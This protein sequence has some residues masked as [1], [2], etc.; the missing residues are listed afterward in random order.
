MSGYRFLMGSLTGRSESPEPDN[1]LL[2]SLFQSC[3]ASGLEIPIRCLPFREK[4]VLKAVYITQNVF[5]DRLEMLAIQN[6]Y[7]PGCG[8]LDRK[9][10]TRDRPVE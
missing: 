8:K 7:Q 6:E 5:S 10:Q 2:N 9:G 3:N 1:D 4:H